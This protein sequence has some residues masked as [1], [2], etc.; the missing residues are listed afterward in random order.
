MSEEL[1]IS[2]S[3]TVNQPQVLQLSLLTNDKGKFTTQRSLGDSILS[4]TV[5]IGVTVRSSCDFVAI[6]ICWRINFATMKISWIEGDRVEV[7]GTKRR[8]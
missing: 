8:Y 2:S 6:Q 4:V 3:W 1:L 5:R 7:T